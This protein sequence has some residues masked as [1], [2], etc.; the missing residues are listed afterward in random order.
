VVGSAR[1]DGAVTTLADLDARLA[2]ILR[3]HESIETQRFYKL[4]RPLLAMAKWRATIRSDATK[5][6]LGALREGRDSTD[7]FAEAIEELEANVAALERIA[8]IRKRSP[9]AH[10]A[11][12]RR[13]VDVLSLAEAGSRE[14]FR[15]DPTALLPPLVALDPTRESEPSEIDGVGVVDVELAAIDH[16]LAAARTETM[17]LGRRRRLLIAARQRLLDASAALPLERDGVRTRTA[18]IAR[19]ILRIDRLEASGLEADVSLLHQARRSLLRREPS[20]LFAALAALDAHAAAAGDRTIAR[21]TEAALRRIVGHEPTRSLERS[22][23]ELLG[24]VAGLVEQAVH[25]AENDARARSSSGGT[26]SEREEAASFLTYLPS[27]SD[28]QLLRS[29]IAADGLFEVGGALAPVRVADEELVHRV[30]RHPTQHMVLVPAEDVNDLRDAI[31]GDPRSIL[32]DLATGRLFARRYVREETRS[33]SRVVMRSEVRVYVLD[34]SG[35]MRGPRARVRD[36]LLIAE[37]STLMRRISS[38]GEVR[39]TLF[40]RYFASLPGKVTRVDTIASATDAIRDIV[41]NERV[42]GTDIERALLESMDQIV[43]AR[44]TDPDLARAQIVL[45]TDGEAAV[46]ESAL[47]SARE[48]LG[49]LPIGIS[50]IALGHENAALR[51][52]V[53]RQRAKGEAAF[54]HFL[55]DS[56]LRTIAEKGLGVDDLVHAPSRLSEEELMRVLEEETGA[57]LDDLESLDRDRDHAALEELEAEA[58]ARREVGLDDDAGDGARARVEAMRR[59][60]VALSA[61]FA[62]WFPEAEPITETPAAGTPE[63]EDVDATCCALASI[64]EVVALVGGTE[65]ARQADAIDL[66]ER[67]LPDAQLTPSRYRAIVTRSCGPVASALR[68][69]REAV[70]PPL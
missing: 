14:K 34:G 54:Y 69:V 49:G 64:A 36:A 15:L 56:E 4:A 51:G 3:G 55:D 5:K 33:R 62:R 26:P 47:V 37:L 43:E 45:V 29:A 44:A 22:A 65:L 20:K 59:D 35:S 53:A 67:M 58:Q 7:A 63:R 9:T 13:V 32:L 48:K 12:L 42:G 2:L 27:G 52:I 25:E 70:H 31:I 24:D 21:R 16:L 40:Y 61:R 18:Y 11:W 30:V 10:A 68:A 41:A 39:C 66:L 1:T 57:L 28:R 50:V 8:V 23:R 6:L 60:R 19:E 17:L 38:P 46:N